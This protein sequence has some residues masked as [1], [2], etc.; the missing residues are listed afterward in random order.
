VSGIYACRIEGGI[1]LTVTL[2]VLTIRPPVLAALLADR[3]GRWALPEGPVA[4]HESL[5]EA[6]HRVLV[7]RTGLHRVFLEQ[8]YTFGEPDRDPAGRTVTVAYYA[9]VDPGRLAG[10][11][12]FDLDVPWAGERGGPVRALGAGGR[13]APLALDHAGIL[14]T[15]VRRIRGKLDYAPIGFQ[16]LPPAFTLRQLQDVHETVL[17]RPLNKDSFRRRMLAS[18]RLRP[19]GERQTDVDHRPAELYRFVRR[20][21]V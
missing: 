3:D 8:L 1:K 12:L 20:A 18:G 14:G 17:G 11:D 10:D 16:L 4:T 13:R 21:A 9:L 2:V 19:T 5:D 15:A 6:A 7:E